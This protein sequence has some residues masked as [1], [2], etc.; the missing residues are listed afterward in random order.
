MY[1]LYRIS[2]WNI[3]FLVLIYGSAIMVRTVQ[4]SVDNYLNNLNSIS[5]V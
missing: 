1:T 5:A 2:S 4:H 3:N